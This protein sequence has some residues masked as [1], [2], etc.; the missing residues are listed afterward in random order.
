MNRFIPVT[1]SKGTDVGGF[2]CWPVFDDEV[3][4][5]RLGQL[6]ELGVESVALGG[7][8]TILTKPILG[9]GHA[10]IVVRAMFNGREVALKCRRTDVDRSMEYEAR[11]LGRVNEVGLGPRLYGF[12]EDFIVM[13]LIDGLYF[14][15]WVRKNLGDLGKVRA[16]ILGIIDIAYRL[17][18]AGVDHGELTKIRR[19]YIVTGEGP[20]VIDFDSGSLGRAPQ[21]LTCTVQSLF[22]HTSFSKMIEEYYVMP[23]RYELLVALK[24][25]K[26]S[27]SWETYRTI[28][29]VVEKGLVS[30]PLY[31]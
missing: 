19:H 14:G 12:S 18:S 1:E 26:T 17:D 15:D 21:N 24:G 16:Y 4:E 7:P 22:L 25:Y 13:E 11:I 2:L 9:K 5:R 20:R 8:H 27:P 28:L 31:N 3:F 10:G 23:D 29:G 6:V 30:D